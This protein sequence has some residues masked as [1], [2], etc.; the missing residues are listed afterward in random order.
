LFDL[1]VVSAVSVVT[2]LVGISLFR[3]YGK[4]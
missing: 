3:R 2:L 4:A 1:T